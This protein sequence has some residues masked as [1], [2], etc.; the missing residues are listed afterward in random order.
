MAYS[1]KLE[2]VTE[3]IQ[4]IKSIEQLNKV[5]ARIGQ[6]GRFLQR[7]IRMYPKRMYSKNPLIRTDPA[8]RRA[9]FYYLNKGLITVPYR[10]T[11]SLMHNW[12]V[13]QS[14][15]GMSVTV[16]NDLPYAPLVQG[17]ETQAKGHQW[18]GWMTD[19]GAIQTYGPEII[20]RIQ[21]ALRKEVEGK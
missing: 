12:V 6:E 10:R 16:E 19:K 21:D 9:F 2:G 14:M 1:V 20:V 4:R 11:R 3:L 17:W 8:V 15:D 18:S 7:K 13:W 5:K